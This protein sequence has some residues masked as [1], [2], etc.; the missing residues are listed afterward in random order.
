[1]LTLT[2]Q[3]WLSSQ[4]KQR[5]AGSQVTKLD[6]SAELGVMNQ[7]YDAPRLAV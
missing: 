6:T 5:P 4:I 7:S 1:M 3:E 2:F